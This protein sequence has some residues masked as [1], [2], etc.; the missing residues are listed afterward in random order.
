M[1]ARACVC[2]SSGG[3]D[4]LEPTQR[5][6]GALL[7]QTEKVSLILKGVAINLDSHECGENYVSTSACSLFSTAPL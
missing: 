4:R 6:K 3:W 1:C 5:L 7:K 2:Q